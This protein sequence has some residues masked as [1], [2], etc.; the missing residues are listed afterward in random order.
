MDVGSI[1]ANSGQQTMSTIGSTAANA[2]TNQALNAASQGMLSNF[3]SLGTPGLSSGLLSGLG[4]KALDFLGSEQGTNAINAGTGLFSGWNQYKTGKDY[5]KIL[6]AQ[7]ARS[8]NAY[9]RD[10]AADEKRQLLNF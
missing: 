6:K 5:S 7:E 1:L 9:N 8:A 3:M 10:V 2:A 4:T